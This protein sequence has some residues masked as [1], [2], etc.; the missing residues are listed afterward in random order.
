[1]ELLRNMARQSMRLDRLLFDSGPHCVDLS[2]IKSYNLGWAQTLSRTHLL[3]FRHSKLARASNNLAVGLMQFFVTRVNSWRF[4]P[5]Q[6]LHFWIG[7][8]LFTV[9]M[10]FGS[11]VLRMKAEHYTSSLQ[12]SWLLPCGWVSSDN[13]A[14]NSKPTPG[15]ILPLVLWRCRLQSPRSLAFMSCMFAALYTSIACHQTRHAIAFYIWISTVQLLCLYMHVYFFVSISCSDFLSVFSFFIYIYIYTCIY[16]YLYIAIHMYFIYAYICIFFLYLSG[17]FLAHVL[18]PNSFHRCSNFTSHCRSFTSL[19]QKWF[20]KHMHAFYFP[21]C[22][23]IYLSY[24]HIHVT[25][26]FRSPP[27]GLKYFFHY[28]CVFLCFSSQRRGNLDVFLMLCTF[29]GRLMG[30]KMT[31]S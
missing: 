20:R 6:K 12:P 4:E 28:F 10:F 17:T 1:M 7:P 27:L 18:R 24:F 2:P 9:T 25:F 8:Q 11:H 31:P 19:P 16:L 14:A 26:S 3:W 15:T 29:R 5:H 23:Q 13:L 22:F 30:T 21:A